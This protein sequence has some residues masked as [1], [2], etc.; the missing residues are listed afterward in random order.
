MKPNQ[1]KPNQTEPNQTKPN[2]TKPTL[3][4]DLQHST[5]AINRLD[6]QSDR[7]Y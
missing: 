2:Q 4:R 3:S 5:L 6:G 7:L 1:T